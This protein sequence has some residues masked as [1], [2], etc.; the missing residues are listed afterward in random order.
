MPESRLV[1]AELPTRAGTPDPRPAAPFLGLLGRGG[2]GASQCPG[3]SSGVELCPSLGRL[4]VARQSC[5]GWSGAA[6]TLPAVGWASGSRGSEWTAV[7]S[8]STLK[9]VC[10]HVRGR[11]WL[12]SRGA[13]RSGCKGETDAESAAWPILAGGRG[14]C[15][16]SHGGFHGDGSQRVWRGRMGRRRGGASAEPRLPSRWTAEAPLRQ[17]TEDACGLR[18]GAGD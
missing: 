12:S 1:F 9:A 7:R 16:W 14:A 17:E 8:P 5:K 4:G 10:W 6:A 2:G 13:L 11:R 15:G 3:S 18:F